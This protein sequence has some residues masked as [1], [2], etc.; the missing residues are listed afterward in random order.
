MA[1]LYIARRAPTPNLPLGRV[2]TT[3]PLG[4][5]RERPNIIIPL[6]KMELSELDELVEGVLEKRNL[7]HL[8]G[9][10]V[11][12]MGEIYEERIKTAEASK[13]LRMRLRE[14]A[15]FS[16]LKLGGLAPVKRRTK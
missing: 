8:K 11:D 4:G 13:E 16:K 5:T 7:K 3:L 14:Q 15:E 6:Y 1:R 2:A 10:L 9:Q 12:K